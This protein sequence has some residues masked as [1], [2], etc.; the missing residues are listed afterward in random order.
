MKRTTI[1]RLPELI[2]ILMDCL[3]RSHNETSQY[4][5]ILISLLNVK[6]IS[7][8]LNRNNVLFGIDWAHV[9]DS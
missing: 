1:I 5:S 3:W 4:A 7:K 9:F 2:V 6:T 8:S